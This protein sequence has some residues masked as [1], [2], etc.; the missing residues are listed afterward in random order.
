MWSH[1]HYDLATTVLRR[2]W[3]FEGMVMTDWWMRKAASPEFPLLRDN[4][5]RV[6]AQV[7]V[8]MPGDL[9]HTA[10]KYRSDGSLLK[11]L[12]QEEGITLGELQRSAGNV[13]RMILKLPDTAFRPTDRTEEKK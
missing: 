12:G 6:R 11:T 5:Y 2:E 4:A 3:G 7:D 1:Y 9:G 10:R 8:L 13:L